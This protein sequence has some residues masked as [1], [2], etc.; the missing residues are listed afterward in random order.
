LTLIRSCTGSRSE[1][2]KL[3]AFFDD[4]D[5]VG[6]I[7]DQEVSAM[8]PGIFEGVNATVFACGA[9][10]SGKTYTMQVRIPFLAS[11]RNVFDEMFSL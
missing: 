2:Y 10:G 11:A 5:R 1:Y 7:F 4:E 3:Y 8:I 6:D 9:T